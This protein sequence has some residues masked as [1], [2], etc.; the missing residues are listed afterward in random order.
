MF[1]GTYSPKLDEKGRLILPAKFR[2]ELEEG[3]VLTRGQ[4]RCVYVFS[5]SEFEELHNRIRQAP[6]TSKQ[7]RD[8]LR[9]LLSGAHAE[10]PDRQNRVTIPQQLRQ[11]AGLDRELAVIGAGSRA[12]IWDAEAW[13]TY[14]AANEAAFSET[15]EEVIPGLF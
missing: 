7:A 6:V 13:N 14:V 10:T 12:E 5:T 1:L 2:D 9:L 11:Y 8:Y 4:D 15:A 3:V